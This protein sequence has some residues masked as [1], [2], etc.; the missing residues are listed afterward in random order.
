MKDW[1]TTKALYRIT[2]IRRGSK[3]EYTMLATGNEV[4]AWCKMKNEFYGYVQ[5]VGG[6]RSYSCFAV[7]VQ[8]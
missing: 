4:S 7:L 6:D 8:Y 2:E 5:G 3:E 1:K